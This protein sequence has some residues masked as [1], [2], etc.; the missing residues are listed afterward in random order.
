MIKKIPEGVEGVILYLLDD[1]RIHGEN[2]D[3]LDE[4]G[5]QVLERFRNVEM[6][7][8]EK[9]EIEFVG[10]AISQESIPSTTENVR[11]IDP[12]YA[13]ARLR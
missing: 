9:C 13:A 12:C 11:A 2:E 3:E 8:D 4:C 1:I 7:L 6:T 10:Y 5:R